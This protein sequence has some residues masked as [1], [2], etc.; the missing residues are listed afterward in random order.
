MKGRDKPITPNTIS[1][2]SVDTEQQASDILVM[3]CK[4]AYDG[5][6]WLWNDFKVGDVM[7]L[8]RVADQ[9]RPFY[10]KIRDTA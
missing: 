8:E 7:E 10:E 4:R 5:E 1:A 3:F 6:S 9:I 2:F